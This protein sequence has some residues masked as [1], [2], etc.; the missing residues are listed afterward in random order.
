MDKKIMLHSQQVYFC[1]DEALAAMQ[2]ECLETLYDYN[3]T[4][5][6]EG[7]KRSN[8]LN[9]L[10][11]SVGKNCYIEPPLRANWGCHT[12]LGDNVYANFNLTL[13]DDTH[14]YIGD[15]VMIG[16]N[17]TIATAG[18]PIDPEL[19]RDIAQF[20]IPVH[21]G[22][23]VWIGANSVVLPGVTIGEN[24]VIGAGS[25]VTKDIPAN[26]VAVGNP[27][28]VLREIGEHDKEFYFRDRKIEQNMF[29]G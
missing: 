2:T 11:A 27:C 28:R 25:V 16:P 13:V 10:L 3:Q 12:H 24:S 29:N 21:I 14:I 5:P 4:R 22:N 6:S 7:E 15:H 20:N 17:V 23:N 9:H 26:V 19:R 18:H 8:I 1:N